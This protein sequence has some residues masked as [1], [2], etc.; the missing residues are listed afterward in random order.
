MD[1]SMWVIVSVFLLTG[2]VAFWRGERLLAW[3]PV[4]VKG[5]A[6]RIVI[7]LVFTIAAGIFGLVASSVYGRVATRRPDK[8]PQVYLWVGV[9]L[10]ILLSIAGFIVPTAL[11]KQGPVIAWTVM[12]LLWGVGYGWVLP[13]LRRS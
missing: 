4:P 7:A 6:G 3:Y 9:G 11:K 8:A 1:K 5:V 2:I 13:W 10:A 12:N